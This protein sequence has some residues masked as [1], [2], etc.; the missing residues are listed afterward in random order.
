MSAH[1]SPRPRGDAAQ[2][3][4]ANTNPNGRRRARIPRNKSYR[5]LP[6]VMV[7][8]LLGVGA[9]A[10]PSVINNTWTP[11]GDDT[12]RERIT[13][14]ALPKDAPEQGLVYSGL[15]VAAAESLCAGAYELDETT[16]THGPDAAPAGL[17]VR[18]GVEPVPGKAPAP[19]SPGRAPATVPTAAALV[20][21]Q[22]GSAL[23]E[24]KPALIPDVAPGEAD[25]V[26]GNHGVACEGDGR[27][28]KRVQAVYLHEF[29]TPSRY[30]DFAGSIGVWSAG[31]DAI[32]D[33]SAAE[34]GGSRHIR[35]VTTPSCRVDVAEVQVPE[36][37]LR[38]FR[39]A[40]DA[41]QTL[42]YNRT[43]RKYLLFADTDVYCGISTYVGDQRPGSGNRNNGGPSYARVDSG[44]WSAA[45]AAHQLT[46]AL[47]AGL[48]G[49]PNATGAGSCTDDFDL[50][51]GKDRTGTPIRTVCPKKHENRLDCGGDDYFHTNPKPDSWLAKNWN[52][53]QSGFLLKGD[54]GD[55][56]TEVSAPD[57]PVVE[58]PSAEPSTA[59][60]AIEAPAAGEASPPVDAPEPSAPVSEEPAVTPER[61]PAATKVEAV[62]EAREATSTEVRLS[63]SAAGRKASYQVAV[64]GVP[65][66]KTTATKARLIGLKP[67]TG[68]RVTIESA[69][70]YRAVATAQTG[71]AARPAQNT[72]FVLE[73]SLTGGAADLYAARTANGAAIVLDGSDGDAQQQW[74][75]VPAGDGAFALKSKATGKCMV[76]LGGNPVAGVPLV[77]GDCAADDRQRWSIGQSEYGFTLRTKRGDL[78]A[79]VGVQRFGAHRLLVLQ[80]AQDGTRHQSWTAVPG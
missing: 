52:V 46:H 80:N 27:T 25:F 68:Y 73:N 24:G 65:I 5:L 53:A 23:T 43:D 32:Y 71:P 6:V 16:C 78:V 29:G 59:P 35:Y 22:G 55:D 67:D 79:G 14:A 36:D 62:L 49:S 19:R 33:A 18:R 39:T 3:R 40:I 21:G 50:L 54:G 26:M 42:G 31:V 66:A 72:Y 44:C 15:T 70:G 61:E 30:T 34:T 57:A 69:G 63:W 28:G 13:L 17:R 45:V 64:D 9:M 48:R 38:T 12:D 77:Q 47:G 10:A 60:P 75:L 2:R 51:C 11:G 8:A 56:T 4:H 1:R 58:E 7:G 76:P 74:M 41:L 20:R 37:S